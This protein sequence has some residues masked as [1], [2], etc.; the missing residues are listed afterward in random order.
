[1]KKLLLIPFLVLAVFSHGQVKIGTNPGTINSNSMLEIESLNK[2]FLPPRV[3]LYGLS[4]V[5]PLSGTVPAGMLVY[6][7]GGD[8]PDGYYYW[9]SNGWK[10]LDN[11]SKTIVPMYL[12]K[13]AEKRKN[14]RTLIIDSAVES[15]NTTRTNDTLP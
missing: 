11:G 7:T 10:K 5:A 15:S 1:M 2:G 14:P 12:K 3:T 4:D 9:N 13:P 6:N 8:L